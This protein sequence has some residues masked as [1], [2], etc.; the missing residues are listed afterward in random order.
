MNDWIDVPLRRTVAYLSPVSAAQRSMILSGPSDRD[1]HRRYFDELTALREIEVG[2]RAPRRAQI[3]GPARV[4]FWNA[5]RLRHIDAICDSLISVNPD[6]A[7][8]CEIDR[9]MART[10]NTDR[11]RDLSERFGYTYAYAVEF[12]ELGLGDLNEQ[13]VHAGSSNDRGLHGAAIFSDTTL[14]SPFLIRIDSRGDWFDGSRH[15][16]RVGG[17][18]ALGAYVTVAGVSMMM[19]NVHLESHGD[20][21][22]RANDMERLLRIIES[23]DGHT[24]VLLGGDFNTSTGSYADRWSDRAAWLNLLQRE[25][26]RLIRPEA[27][28]PLFACAARFGYEWQSCNVANVSTQRFPVDDDRPRMKLDWFFTRDLVASDPQIVAA[29]RPDGLPSSDHDAL[30]VTVAA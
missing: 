7:L 28:E 19:V 21:A 9:G 4:V 22:E 17:T 27:Y 10:Q 14:V 13:R 25:P 15:E 2:G 16:P 24:P 20:P 3:G 29:L 6:V 5:E 11:L 1:T 8:I 18:I 12:V 26:G 23:C 30:A